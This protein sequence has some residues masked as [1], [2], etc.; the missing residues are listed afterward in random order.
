MRGGVLPKVPRTF[1]YP[2]AGG[3][4]Y[5]FAFTHSQYELGVIAGPVGDCE[6]AA[7]GYGS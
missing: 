4:R 1:A 2:D 6:W 5:W 7:L 3:Y